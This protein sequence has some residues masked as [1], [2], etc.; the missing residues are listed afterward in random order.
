MLEVFDEVL[1]ELRADG[2]TVDAADFLL[3]ANEAWQV[4]KQF[5]PQV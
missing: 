1:A 3:R 2:I 5:A 4:W